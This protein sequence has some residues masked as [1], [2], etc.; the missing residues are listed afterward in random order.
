VKDFTPGKTFRPG[1]IDTEAS[2]WLQ[3][4]GP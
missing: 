1:V 2:A 4:K 3:P